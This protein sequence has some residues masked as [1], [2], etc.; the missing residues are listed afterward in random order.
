MNKVMNVRDAALGVLNEIE[1]NMAYSGVAVN[2]QV[3]R[4][5]AQTDPSV[6]TSLKEVISG[7]GS[8]VRNNRDRALLNELVFGI[9]RKKLL[10]DYIISNFSK[11]PEK[12]INVT[13]KNIIRL[14]VYQA[15]FLD[16]IPASA[17]CDESVK[18]A[19]KHGHAGSV[20]FVNAVLRSVTSSSPA[21]IMPRR[22]EEAFAVLERRPAQAPQTRQSLEKA[23][24]DILKFLSVYYSFPEW[25]C[26]R[27]LIR[28]GAAFC[29]SLLSAY[30]EQPDFTIRVN[31]LKTTKDELSN[32][33]EIEGYRI[34]KAPYVDDA[35]IIENP[36]GFSSTP[37]FMGGLFTVQGVSSMLCVKA[38][39]PKVGDR[40][41]DMCAAPGGKSGY[42]AEITG[43]EAN[44]L[45]FDVHEHKIGLMEQNATRLGLTCINTMLTDAG[46]FQP[47]LT[48]SM[49]K[50]LV[51]APC[52][53]FGSL[54]KK[55][56]IKWTKN[57]DDI[58]K[59]VVAQKTILNTAA[60]YVKAGGVIV[61]CVCT[62][63]PEEGE[64]I[65]EEFLRTHTSFRGSNLSKYLPFIRDMQNSANWRCERS[66]ERSC[67]R[68]C[69]RNRD[70]VFCEGDGK[71]E[72]CTHETR[73]FPNTHETRLFPNTHEMRPFTNTH[74]TRLFP[75]TH[76]MRLF[77]NM[78]EGVD[79]FYIARLEKIFS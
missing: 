30:N 37:E 1:I 79:G 25:L 11:L 48:D 65:I 50:V 46:V 8:S 4:M 12:K 16:K 67:E 42:I 76:E 31:R 57:A 5:A 28:Y 73:S 2:R 24:E 58:A 17:A 27:W 33:L 74:E 20:R 66:F 71:Y 23:R 21:D 61:Y 49:D 19:K 35:L 63:E 3:K 64:Y 6:K 59:L 9:M 55:P 54:R 72:Q 51:D 38:L 13:I 34:S 52:S 47:A 15:V 44:V 43:N 78:H 75:N 36:A 39:D 56:D 40:I 41:L 60:K 22:P 18:L 69:E 14:G 7:K 32:R 29:E 68:S 26:E 70:D 77:P 53:G 45:A 62:T 10:I